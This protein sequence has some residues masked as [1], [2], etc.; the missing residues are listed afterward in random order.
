MA[1]RKSRIEFSKAFH[2]WA[3][4]RKLVV[5]I[6]SEVNGPGVCGAS[7]HENGLVTIRMWDADDSRVEEITMPGHHMLALIGGAK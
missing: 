7:F 5:V 3:D 4:S 1:T 2:L 6:P